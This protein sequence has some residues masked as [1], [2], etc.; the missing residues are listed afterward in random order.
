MR[1]ML[2]PD[3]NVVSTASMQHN[4]RIRGVGQTYTDTPAVPETTSGGGGGFWSWLG[5][6]I[7]PVIQSTAPGLINTAAGVPVT[8]RPA[9]TATVGAAGVPLA[10]AAP[11]SDTM[12]WVAIAGLGGV[13]LFMVMK[14]RRGR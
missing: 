12:K 4:S 3:A 1:M 13:L 7:S 14:R 5:D 2:L 6:T 11:K 8:P 9:T 10:G